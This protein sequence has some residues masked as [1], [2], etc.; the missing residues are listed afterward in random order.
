MKMLVDRYAADIKYGFDLAGAGNLYLPFLEQL[1]TAN[2]QEKTLAVGDKLMWM[3]FRSKGKV[4]IIRDVEWA[5]KAPLEVFSFN[6]K[7]DSKNYEFLMPKP[8]GNI[9]LYKI[10]EL[11]RPEAVCAITVSPAKAN[12]K[13]VITVDMSGSRNAQSMRVDVLDAAGAKIASQTLTA[14]SPRW[15]TSFDKPGEYTFQAVALNEDGKAS[16][17]PCK[18][19]TYL[20]FPPVCK[21]WT[22]CLPCEDYVGKT[23]VFDASGS[24]DADGQ[25]AKANFELTDAA[26]NV[27]DTFL[28]TEKPFTWEKV[29]Q[30]PGVYTITATV[31]DDM[32]SAD[33]GKEPCRLSFEVTQKRLY[34]LLE[35]GPMLVHGTYTTYIFGRVGILYKL[36]PNVLD[37]ILS[38]GGALPTVGD[39]WKFFFLGNALL[40]VNAGPVFAGGGLGFSTKDQKIGRKGGID[41]VGNAGV[42]IFNRY[43]S[44]GAVFFEIRVPV[45][46]SDRS[47][48][49]HHK[50]GIGFRYLF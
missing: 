23:I 7:Q 4:K 2:F 25:I 47:F 1:R 50:F 44:A 15:Q 6:V 36:V 9:S 20:N 48:E 29:F 37:L 26:G 35:A 14:A 24:T 30:K 27:V 3:L 16:V 34:Y 19:K 46:T 12:T 11:A 33:G 42:Y 40:N 10:T 5:G 28:D 13:D 22:S 17:N 49:D 43:T 38:A 39:P 8:C 32:G 31:F 45:I 21:L 18:A 41:L